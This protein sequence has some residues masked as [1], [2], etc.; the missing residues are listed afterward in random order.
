MEGWREAMARWVSAF[1][2]GARISD[3]R[4]QELTSGGDNDIVITILEQGYGVGYFPVLALTHIIPPGRLELAHQ[5]RLSRGI[6]RSW[7]EVL[8]LHGLSPWKPIPA[9]SRP[10]RKARAWLRHR[11]WESP[12]QFVRWNAACGHFEGRAALSRRDGERRS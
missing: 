4:G 2:E 3:R 6:A 10:L 12:A 7:V 1:V 11:P 5:G 9:W 8:A